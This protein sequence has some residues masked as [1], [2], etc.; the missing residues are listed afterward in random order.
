MT[1]TRDQII[2]T[3]RS[4]LETQG[5]HATGL[6]QIVKESGAPKGSLY[7]YFPEGKEEITEEAIRRAGSYVTE[8][9]TANLAQIKDAADA[10]EA[11]IRTIA[12]AVEASEFQT[13]GP[14]MTVAME[15]TTTSVRLNLACREAYTMLQAAFQIRLEAGGYSPQRAAQLATFVTAGIEGGTVLS[16][17]YHSGDPLRQI[18]V[19]M[20][21]YLR[22][23]R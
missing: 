1:S 16:R 23:A 18:A 14:L 15:T 22:A 9:I 17:T 7:H 2:E 10:I 4:L 21:N 5:Y 8:R 6:N 20:G 12:D 3:T 11:L 13:G 19:E